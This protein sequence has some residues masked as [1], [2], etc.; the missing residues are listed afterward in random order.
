MPDSGI[1]ASLRDGILVADGAMGTML[2][3][4]GM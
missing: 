4:A 1:L 3:A 2:E